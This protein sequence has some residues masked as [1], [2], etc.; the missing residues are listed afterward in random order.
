MVRAPKDQEVFPGMTPGEI[1]LESKAINFENELMRAA[2]DTA[3][4]GL[5]VISE[6]GQIVMVGGDVAAKLGTTAGALLGQPFRNLRVPG[7]VLSA[8]PELFALDADEISSE[9]RLTGPNDSL[10]VLMFQA[11]TLH[12]SNGEKFRVLSII[13]LSTFGITRTRFL[14]LR[15]QLDSINSSVVVTDAKQADMPIVWVNRSFEKLTG[16]PAS[17]AIGR[18]CRFLQ[19]QQRSQPAA[20]K[21]REAIARHQ[22]CQVILTNFRRDGTEF[23]NDMFVSPLYDKDGELTHYVGFLR[24]CSGRVIPPADVAISA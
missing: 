5:C 19:N 9:A 12:H 17:Q 2:L 3:R 24:E 21:L 16:Y 6:D 15:R 1:H 8:G 23:S 4:I 7:L 14:E 20:G 11:R 18:N 22:S 10:K 13:D